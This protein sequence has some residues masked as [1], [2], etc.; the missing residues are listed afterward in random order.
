MVINKTNF[1]TFYTECTGRVQARI[2]INYNYYVEIEIRIGSDS[3]T[4]TFKT[5]TKDSFGSLSEWIET[6]Y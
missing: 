5:I 4:S 1:E 6:N 3:N 2:S